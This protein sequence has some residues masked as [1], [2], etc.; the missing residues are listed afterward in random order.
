ML[1]ANQANVLSLSLLSPL[2]SF[3]FTWHNFLNTSGLTFTVIS[4]WQSL[5]A[6]PQ[7]SPLQVPSQLILPHSLFY[8]F[9][10]VNKYS[11]LGCKLFEIRDHIDK[12]LKNCKLHNR[13][14]IKFKSY[15]P[16]HNVFTPHCGCALCSQEAFHGVVYAFSVPTATSTYWNVSHSSWNIFVQIAVTF[17]FLGPW[18]LFFLKFTP[19][20]TNI[21]SSCPLPPSCNAI[22]IW[23]LRCYIL[24]FVYFQPD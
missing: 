6:P 23:L 11:I 20:L 19:P 21:G 24:F 14:Q 8:L 10:Y 15:G 1:E 5:N 2:P 13:R 4:P 7:T 12:D 3:I 18:P 16:S 17:T 22:W 9:Q